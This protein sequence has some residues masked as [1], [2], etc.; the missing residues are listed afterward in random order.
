MSKRKS[1]YIP[2]ATASMHLGSDG[3]GDFFARPL[4]RST[5]RYHV[6]TACCQMMTLAFFRIGSLKSHNNRHIFL[7]FFSNLRIRYGLYNTV[8]YTGRTV[9]FHQRC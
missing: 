3:V 9:Q 5:A 7:T 4:L 6:Q 8:G 1:A 2:A